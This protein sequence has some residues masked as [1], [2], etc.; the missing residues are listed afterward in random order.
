MGSQKPR[1]GAGKEPKKK[2]RS[3]RPEKRRPRARRAGQVWS[4]RS[5]PAGLVQSGRAPWRGGL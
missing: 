2:G 1:V 3:G 5:D 4:R